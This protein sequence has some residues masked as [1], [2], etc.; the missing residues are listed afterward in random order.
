MKNPLIVCQCYIIISTKKI[1]K[2]DGIYCIPNGLN[3]YGVYDMSKSL[4]GYFFYGELYCRDYYEIQ[5]VYYKLIKD[6]MK[7]V[8][9]MF[10]I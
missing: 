2:E 8:V 7:D 4:D 9:E 6:R 3:K 5:V 10:K 1:I